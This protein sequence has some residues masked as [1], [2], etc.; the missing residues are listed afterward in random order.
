[1]PLV[2]FVLHNV[3]EVKSCTRIENYLPTLF[4]SAVKWLFGAFAGLMPV[5]ADSGF[6]VVAV[7][8]I[9]LARV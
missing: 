5:S 6:F 2:K 4:D 7:N 8:K 1:M 3:G 9:V